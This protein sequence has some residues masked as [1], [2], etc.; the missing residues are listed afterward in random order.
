MP[1]PSLTAR[2]ILRAPSD[3]HR[4]QG[5]LLAV[6][7]HLGEAE[8][9]ELLKTLHLMAEAFLELHLPA[10]FLEFLHTAHGTA[11]GHPLGDQLGG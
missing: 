10:E 7:D 9:S 8:L 3:F 4:L 5:R 11:A 1:H 2:P 6:E